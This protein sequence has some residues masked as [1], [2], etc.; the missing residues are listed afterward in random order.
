MNDA[1]PRRFLLMKRGLYYA[2]NRSGYTGLRDKAGRYL[3][4]DAYPDAGVTAV[5]EDLAP[6]FA[7]ACCAHVKAE[8]IAEQGL[9]ELTLETVQAWARSATLDELEQISLT[10]KAT[11]VELKRQLA[12]AS[13]N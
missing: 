8:Y 7:P 10:I 5:R 12:G 6:L 2:P 3:E 13:I 4:S 11:V 9:G 1:T